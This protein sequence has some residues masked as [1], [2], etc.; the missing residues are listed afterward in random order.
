MVLLHVNIIRQFE[1]EAGQ[2]GPVQLQIVVSV[3]KHI[4]YEV[5]GHQ[6]A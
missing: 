1:S 3:V 4:P 2:T 5:L 6:P